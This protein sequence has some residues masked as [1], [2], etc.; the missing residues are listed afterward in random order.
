M[1]LDEYRERL[2]RAES[3]LSLAGD[4]AHTTAHGEHLYSKANGVRLAISYLDEM[5]K[6]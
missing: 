4:K 5:S 6:S 1:N 3:T 2:V